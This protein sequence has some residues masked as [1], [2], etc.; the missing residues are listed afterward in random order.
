MRIDK[1]EINGFKSFSDKTVLTFHHGITAIVGPNGCGKSNLVD[2]FKWVLGEQSVK[3]LRGLRMEDIIFAGSAMQKPKGMAEV[4]LHFSGIE[5][6]TISDNG[7]NGKNAK[8]LSVGRRL[9][10]SGD[11]DYLIDKKSCRLKDIRDALLDTGLEMKAYSIFEQGRVDEILNSKPQDRRFLIE[12]IAGI[13]K[14]K[15]RKSETLKK[16]SDSRINLQRLKDIISEV[17]RQL[18]SVSRHAQKAEKYKQIVKEL[19]DIEIRLAA[20]DYRELKEGLEAVIRQIGQLTM[21]EEELLRKKSEAESLL[22]EYKLVFSDKEKE[23]LACQE[24][25][26]KEEKSSTEAEGTIKLIKNQLESLKELTIRLTKDKEELA[27]HRE[28][29]ESRIE[30]TKKELSEKESHGQNLTCLIEEHTAI[31]SRI[32]D[33]IRDDEDSLGDDRKK[34]LS[35]AEKTINLRNSTINF[36]STVDEL[37]RKEEKVNREH[38]ETVTQV[39]QNNKTIEDAQKEIEDLDKE[40]TL[41]IDKTENLRTTL[42]TRR[43]QL[44]S[45]EKLLSRKR[46][47]LAS[48]TSRL[49]S[50]QE[51]E[52]DVDTERVNGLVPV[53]C[54]IADIVETDPLYERAIEAALGQKL[55]LSIVNNSQNIKEALHFVKTQ[56]I[57]RSGFVCLDTTDDFAPSGHEHVEAIGKAADVVKVKMEFK[58]LISRLLQNIF[59]VNDLETAFKIWTSNGH[60]PCLVT[61]DGEVLQ[62]QGLA[63]GGKERGIL[64]LKRQIREL[65]EQIDKVKNLTQ[66]IKG[67]IFSLEDDITA[68][69]SAISVE[70]KKTLSLEK[71]RERARMKCESLEKDK[72]R[73]ERRV[74]YL[75][76]EAKEHRSSLVNNQKRL[77]ETEKALVIAEQEKDALNEKMKD[78]QAA[79]D[80]KKLMIESIK[81]ELTD[82]KILSATVHEN[83]RTLKNDIK[84]MEKGKARASDKFI[85][86]EEQ[87]QEAA[88]E[89]KN[90]NNKLAQT[91]EILTST[92]SRVSELTDNHEKLRKSFN[93]LRS[94][95]ENID[96]T[97]RSLNPE[98][99][100]VRKNISHHELQKTELTMKLSYIK[101]N[102][103]STYAINIEIWPTVTLEEGD[104]EKVSQ[105]KKSLENLGAVN[106][107]TLEEYEELKERY[108]FLTSQQDD[109]VQSIE[110][111]ESIIKKIN[112]TSRRLLE[113]AYTALNEKFKEVFTRLFGSGRAELVLLEGD[114][115]EAGIEIIAQPPGKK[116]QSLL[117]LSGG[118][119]ALTAI[120][121]LFAGFMI[122]PTPLCILDEV[123]APL[124][125]AN[126]DRFTSLIRELA[127]NIQF[128][129]VTHNK[130]VMEAADYIYGVTMQ[131]AGVSRIVSLKLEH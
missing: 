85:H 13:M 75:L 63:Y 44:K 22:E 127:G 111:L 69:R 53:I 33:E 55:N 89:S 91:E 73:L 60:S 9:F 118:E 66:E 95:T 18:K 24:Q 52:A 56:E 99:E 38:Q 25:L 98:L 3:S 59:I 43:E 112:T 50:L 113:N 93:S 65:K 4:T 27:T 128:I 126:T 76:A 10:R 120:A 19:K 94:E 110:S 49:E 57:K 90:K 16:I 17:E 8:E 62:P 30:K 80:E 121:L 100:E 92:M 41:Q 36:S 21:R 67:V 107:N 12:E 77:E 87:L 101:E 40:L 109:L 115:L 46:E 82:K 124:D 105:L 84:T 97:L 74:N 68:I 37:S 131:E 48:F 86:I 108:D 122:K 88:H 61:L 104:R 23:L 114:I 14:Y 106:L 29:L 15:V 102:M 51:I 83:I 39:E 123:D 117:S 26:R 32:E 20:H 119:K 103:T 96:N 70:D 58:A 6:E 47:D 79:I 34:L 129:M 7:S 2:A 42:K 35:L 72:T 116:S 130:R 125:E 64:A 54:Q 28:R 45:Q 78:L 11:S 1:I 81:A 71:E 5:S 31:V